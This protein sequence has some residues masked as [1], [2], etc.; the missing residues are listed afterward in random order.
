MRK[1]KWLKRLLLVVAIFLV[2]LLGTTL[3]LWRMVRAQP[4]FYH[5]VSLPR[6]Q[7]EAAAQSATNKFATIHNQAA[8][9]HAGARAAKAA[10]NPSGSTRDPVAS[11]PSTSPNAISVTF[12]DT[13][14]N[15]FFEKWSN[16]QNWK[17]GYERYVTDPVVILKDGR[18]IIAGKL[19]DADL[20]ASLHFEPKVTPDGKLDLQLV[21]VLGGT[22][23]LPE[24]LVSGY[25]QKIVDAL[26]RNLPG[27]QQGA[28]FD[29]SGAANRQ[30]IAATMSKF[31][32]RVLNHEPSEPVLFLP[33]FG[34]RGSVPVH[35]THVQIDDGSMTLTVEPLNHE[36]QAALLE[37]ARSEEKTIVAGEGR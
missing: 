25:E 20:I 15:A 6:E 13:E 10:Q 4:D 27:W 28:A 33:I 8:R 2:A 5:V 26:R 1:H 17:G 7:I 34:Q 24:A 11:S 23:P 3:V 29:S 12:T 36:Q 14:L 35:L 37:H 9:I 31:C 21:R 16:F 18:I 22:L 30:L 19:K 32:V